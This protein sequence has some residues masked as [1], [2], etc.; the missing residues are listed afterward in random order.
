M[1]ADVREFFAAENV[2]AAMLLGHS[3]GGKVAMRLALDE[4]SLVKKLVVA[5]V[6]PRAYARTH[7]QIC[8]PPG[9]RSDRV[10]ASRPNRRGTR[11]QIPS[12]ALRRFL[13]KSLGRDEGGR[14][15]WKMNV[16]SLY[17]NY[18]R[19]CQAVSGQGP[20]EVRRSSFAAASPHTSLRRMKQTS[21]DNSPRQ[22]SQPFHRPA[23]GSTPTPR[24][25]SCGWCLVFC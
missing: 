6:A 5:D 24:T 14:F 7:D 25:S 15:F 17:E 4:P 11:E 9:A 1:A 21:A 12:L 23:T 8:R 3:M 13:L 10:R 2:D 16:R 18:D 22:G 19:L 20:F